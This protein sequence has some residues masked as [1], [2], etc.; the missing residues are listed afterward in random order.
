MKNILAMAALLLP[1]LATANNDC[2]SE[3]VMATYGIEQHNKAS[4]SSV[5]NEL[6]LLRHN[7]NV[8]HINDKKMATQWTNLSGKHMKKTSYFMDD[9]RAIEYDATP[10][11]SDYT[12]RYHAQLLHPSFKKQASLVATEGLGCDTLE[13][14]Q[15]KTQAKTVDVWWYPHKKLVKRIESQQANTTITWS[16][17]GSVHDAAVVQQYLSELYAYQATDFADIGDNESDPF[18]RKMINL[19]FVE[20]GATGFYD[21]DGNT[22]PAADHSHQ[23]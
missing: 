13:Y 4:A 17:M 2:P 16:L 5:K 11:S 18:F 21:T 1:L 8:V 22:L 7:N 19:G 10:V 6:I 14:Y 23:H 20:H 3:I 12:W 9:L 15:Q